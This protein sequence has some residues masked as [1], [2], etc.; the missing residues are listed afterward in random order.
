MKKAKITAPIMLTALIVVSLLPSITSASSSEN[1]LRVALSSLKHMHARFLR[2][3]TSAL[4]PESRLSQGDIWISVPG[5]FRW[6]LEGEG[7]Q[8]II[9]DGRT[10]WIYDK[11]VEQITAYDQ[12]QALNDS[13]ALLLSNPDSL[14]KFAITATQGKGGGDW[15]KLTPKAANFLFDEIR[16]K[17]ANNRTQQLVIIKYDQSRETTLRFQYQQFNQP[18][19]SELFQFIPPDGVDIIE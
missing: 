6:D 1:S 10:L 5:K 7:A 12:N 13:P 15:Y 9:A 11:E 2:I 8:S 17:I 3:E 16:L 19:P 4:S 18:L 14:E